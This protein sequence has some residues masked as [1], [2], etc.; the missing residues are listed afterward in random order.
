MAALAIEL[1]AGR[2]QT[3]GIAG[4]ASLLDSRFSLLWRGRRTAIPRH[5]TLGAALGWSYDLLPPAESG[6][7][8]RLSVFVGPFTLQAALAVI[9]SHEVSESEAV[10]IIA[11]LLFTMSVMLLLQYMFSERRRI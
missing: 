1:A 4:I 2:V 3:Y 6:A 8:R 7:L 11:S 5:Q 10:E 9:A